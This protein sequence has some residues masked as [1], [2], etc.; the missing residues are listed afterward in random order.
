MNIGKLSLGKDL[1]KARVLMHLTM[2]LGIVGSIGTSIAY[3]Q[4]PAVGPVSSALCSI[5]SSVSLVLGVFALIMFILGGTIYAFAHF[6]PAAGNLK[7]AM[8]GW[9]MGMLMGGIIALVLYILAPY[10]VAKIIGIS[11]ASGSGGSGYAT[12]TALGVTRC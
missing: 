5:I 10:I 2:L 4:S 6:L 12:V 8:Q 1:N 3:A 7:G 11:I 9:G